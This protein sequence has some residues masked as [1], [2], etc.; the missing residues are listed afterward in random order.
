MET[1]SSI[2]NW[3]AGQKIVFRFLSIYLLFY[4]CS[5]QFVTVVVFHPIWEFVVPLVGKYILGFS[6]EI[7]SIRSGSGDGIFSYVSIFTYF[8]VAI[9]GAVVWTFFDKNRKNYQT[10]LDWLITLV[11]Y[12]VAFQ[13]LLYGM[14]KLVG[15]QFGTLIPSQLIRTYGES[16]PMGLLWTFMAASKGYQIFTGAAEVLG[17]VLLLW[18]RTTTLGALT[19][20]GVMANVMALNFFYDVPVKLLSTHLV[21]MSLLLIALDGQRLFDFFFKNESTSSCTYRELIPHPIF[22]K[23]KNG[24]KIL[25]LLAMTGGMGYMVSSQKKAMSMNKD[26]HNMKGVYEV[27]NFSRIEKDFSIIKD[28][29]FRW[30]YMI[31]DFPG[32]LTIRTVSGQKRYFQYKIDSTLQYLALGLRMDSSHFDTLHVVHN[33]DDEFFIEGNLQGDSIN[34]AL[35]KKT[36][37]DFLLTNRGF[38]WI[39]EQPFNR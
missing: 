27:Q 13:L 22:L 16:S 2:P 20:F 31:I 33:Q 17:G 12:Y 10:L 3:T 7:H 14:A 34:V 9:I 39:S 32:K 30:E 24:L 23:V 8:L 19:V 11:R 26:V 1:I 21:I 29:P 5:N 25:V 28:D 38:H 35:R 15:G 37:D 36:F 18:K 6:E 4:I